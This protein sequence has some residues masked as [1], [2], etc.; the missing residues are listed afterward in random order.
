MRGLW[1]IGGRWN[2]RDHFLE[3]FSSLSH[4]QLFATPWTA[5]HQAFLSIIN[6]WSLLKLM[7]I[8]LVMHPTISSFVVPFSFCLQSFPASKS[9]PM[10][11][12]F[13]SSG[14]KY[15]GFSFRISPATEAE[16]LRIGKFK[17]KRKEEPIGERL[18]IQK[19][20]GIRKGW[21]TLLM[22]KQDC[23]NSLDGFTKISIESQN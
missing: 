16:G 3:Q 14:Q 4:V 11:Q 6:C 12:Y 7:S 23:K 21:V 8:E 2:R 18:E 5:A 19:R 1:R 22:L 15:W 9:F 13:A 17:F 20:E 10:S